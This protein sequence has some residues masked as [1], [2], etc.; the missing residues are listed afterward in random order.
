MYKKVYYR[1]WNNPENPDG[2]EYYRIDF[3]GIEP[4][5]SSIYAV[6][7]ISPDEEDGDSWSV[8]L[9]AQDNSNEC[10]Y[11]FSTDPKNCFTESSREEFLMIVAQAFSL[12]INATAQMF[13]DTSSQLQGTGSQ[14]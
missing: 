4:T 12:S 2:T 7:T 14:P 3:R 5:C 8:I 9:R 11:K 6:D 10:M 13:D 1:K